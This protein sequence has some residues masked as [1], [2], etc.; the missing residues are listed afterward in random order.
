MHRP[1]KTFAIAAAAALTTLLAP[2]AH[3]QGKGE[4]VKFQDYPGLGNSMIR[5][6]I[7]KG[8]CTKYG[9]KC[10]LQTIPTSP[11]GVQAMMAKSIE[12]ALAPV[13]AVNQA[14]LRGG[15]MKM[16]AGG[17]VNSIVLLAFGNHVE[18]PNLAKGWPHFMQDL[19]GK[20]IGVPARGSAIEIIVSWMME[21]AGMDPT[22]D[23]T[24]VATG[25]V[26]TS[27]GTLQS[28]QVDAVFSYDPLGTICDLAKTCKVAWRADSAK[29]PA[30]IA[31]TNGGVVNQ[32]FLQEY[33]DK[34][35]HVVEA[36]IAAVKD[37]AA[38]INDPANFDEMLK[39]TQGYFKLDMP[40]GDAILAANLKHYIATK[41]FRAGIDRN[42]V[43]A[44]LD[45]S[46]ATKSIDKVA[47]VADIVYD[48][49]P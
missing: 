28:K 18:T 20:K 37:S 8:Y 15:K 4:T 45:L 26:P 1:L 25:A 34:N 12:S 9:I 46:L 24:F 49:A 44:S 23:V 17:Q 7:A 33:I 41:N 38:F 2:A 30:E 32:V 13:D 14:V 21:R 40:Q 35:P 22:K 47:G 16:V 29:D 42:A 36:T 48:R 19:K 43:Q 11:L 6:A 39:I 27:Y 31:A 3:A 5:V 10:E